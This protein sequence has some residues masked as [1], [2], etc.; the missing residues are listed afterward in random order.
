MGRRV[1]EW[2]GNLLLVAFSTLMGLAA[3]EI[4]LRVASRFEAGGKEQGERNTYTLSDPILG[5]RKK[6]GAHASYTRRDFTSEFSINAHG[7]RGAD[8]P[9]ERRAG[10]ARLLTLGDSFTEAFMVPDEETPSVRLEK[11]LEGVLAC[12][13]EVVNG[14]TV[15]Y[16]TDQEY[17]FYREEGRRYAPDVVVLFTYHND[18][19]YLVRDTYGRLPKPRLDFESSPPRVANEPVPAYDP[20]PPVRIPEPPLEGS[21]LWE[22]VKHRVERHSSFM[23]N[24]LARYGLWEPLRRFEMNEELRLYVVPPFGHLNR[25]WSAYTWTLES[26]QALV[27]EQGGRLVVA[28]IP[29][30]MEVNRADYEVTMSRYQVDPSTFDPG[31]VSRRIEGIADH[32]GIPYL[33]L[34]PAIRAKSGLLVPA[35]YAT[36]SHWNARG[37]DIA[38][39][40]V[41]DFLRR[42]NLISCPSR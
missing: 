12:P 18:I 28:Y 38:A 35:Y 21:H 33:D 6:P 5:W 42:R 17:L 1:P 23:Y 15:G 2:A 4:G 29:S 14:G 26:L 9:Y 27:A 36:D 8:R 30:R 19:P 31:A 11:R 13:V 37:M 25:A 34:T 24:R 40:A 41:Q 10:V 32:L 22:F 3:L 20:V 16:S 7:L 39:D